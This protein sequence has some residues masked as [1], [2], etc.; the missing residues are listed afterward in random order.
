MSTSL[1]NL[2]SS[3][4]YYV[5]DLADGYHFSVDSCAYVD[6]IAV[7]F[8]LYRQD[9]RSFVEFLALRMQYFRTKGNEFHGSSRSSPPSAGAWPDSPRGRRWLPSPVSPC[10]LGL[11]RPLDS[12]QSPPPPASARLASQRCLCW[13]PSLT[14]KLPCVFRSDPALLLLPVFL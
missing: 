1:E 7:D 5:V 4:T 8:V 9:S 12:S 10:A 3:S 6:V 14:F 13:L 11:P 2:D